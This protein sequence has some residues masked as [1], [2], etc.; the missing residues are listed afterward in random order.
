MY[1][2]GICTVCWRLMTWLRQ[3]L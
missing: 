1:G 3:L 2:V